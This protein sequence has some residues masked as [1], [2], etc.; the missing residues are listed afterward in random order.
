MSRP[1]EAQVKIQAL[2]ELTKLP[3]PSAT[4][5]LKQALDGVSPA[6]GAVVMGTGIVSVAL[7]S[8]RRHVLSLVLLAIAAAA[9][10]ALGV[11]SAVR[12]A[13]DRRWLRQESGSAATLTSVAATAV[14]AARAI[15]VGWS[16]VAA[17]LL[18]IATGLWL[19][20]LWP[21]L[22]GWKAPV[23]GVGF[24]VTVSTESLA[25]GAAQLA[26]RDHTTWL[27]YAALGLL[28]VGLVLYGFVLRSFDFRQILVGAGDHWVSGGA[29]AISALAA[30]RIVLGW[31]DL[32]QAHAAAEPLKVLALVIWAS[33]VAWLPALLAA[34]VRRPRLAYDV[35]RWATVFPVGM[36]AAC[37][38][39]MGRAANVS[40]LTEFARVWVWIGFALWVLVGVSG[41]GR[42]LRSPAGR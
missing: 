11:L 16:G 13:G 22:R 25:V 9:W 40:G 31:Q 18:V 17:A 29:L 24:M 27:L 5:A 35:R 41:A 19:V 38:F 23:A 26:V 1:A 2:P 28:V 42:V 15:G 7:A 34:E 39:D 12:A 20:L 36:Y 8:D 21:V 3:T 14:L 37:S 6:S 10:V 30:A 4:R 32:H 33:A